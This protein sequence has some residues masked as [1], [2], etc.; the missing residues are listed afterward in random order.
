MTFQYIVE[1]NGPV[2]LTV[3]AVLSFCSLTIIVWRMWLNYTAK[4]NLADFL[5]RLQED[6]DE[7]GRTAALELC[8]DEPGAIPKVF[9][10]AVQTCDQGKVATR[11]AMA[12]LIELEIVPDLNFLLPF[13][14]VL[15][16][17][18]PMVGLLGTVTGMIR[19]FGKIA[20][21]TKISPDALAD[22]IGMALF[23]TAEGLIVAIPLIFAYTMF[24]ERVNRFELDLQRAAQAALN[25]LPKLAEKE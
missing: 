12:N 5:V 6:L 21:E 3:F 15:S 10:T 23:T 2:F 14:L 9:A 20:A 24:R 19:A 8:E 4:T 11:N 16:K 18:A 22:D 25:L 7:G 17:L 1:S 13:I